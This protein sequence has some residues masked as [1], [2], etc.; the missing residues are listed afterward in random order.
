MQANTTSLVLTDDFIQCWYDAGSHLQRQIE[1]GPTWVRAHL[2]HP[3]MEHLSFRL[4]NQL[5]FVRIEDVGGQLQ[6]PG[7]EEELRKIA[8][9][10]KGHACIMP[11]K[12]A[13]G[14][15]IPAEKGWGLVSLKDRT[16]V[17]PPDLVTD[18]KI[19]MT[20]W[21]LHDFAVQVVRQ[22]LIESGESV[23]GWNSNPEL[24]P[25]IWLGGDTGLQWIVVQ[26]VRYPEEAK[27][28][29]NIREIEAAYKSK[30]ARGNFAYVSFA[31]EN[32]QRETPLKE[33]EKPLPIYR[34]EKVFISYSG[35]LDINND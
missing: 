6:T 25:S 17:N 11:M 22:N 26:A 2:D 7:S 31:N 28:P 14:H 19:E 4:G 34:G 3:I 35:L 15:W 1:G 32:Q 20:D 18:E 10:C 27:I 12:F 5:F 23:T 30:G 21:E 16:P 24:Q 8:E 33:G 9:K 29:D 13:F